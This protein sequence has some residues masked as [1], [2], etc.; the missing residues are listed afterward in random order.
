MYGDA[1]LEAVAALPRDEIEVPAVK[2]AGHLTPGDH[3]VTEERSLVR[4]DTIQDSHLSLVVEDGELSSLDLQGTARAVGRQLRQGEQLGPLELALRLHEL[5]SRPPRSPG[6]R[7]HPMTSTVKEK[8]QGGSV[9]VVE[10]PWTALPD[11]PGVS[12][13]VSS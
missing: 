12:G 5:K 2:G 11:A 1:L 10:A 9:R 6:G 8:D 13:K 7:A 3:P 4:T